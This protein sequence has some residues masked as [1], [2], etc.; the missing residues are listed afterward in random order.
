VSPLKRQPQNTPAGI[1]GRAKKEDFHN[2]T[3][4][5]GDCGG[6]SRELPVFRVK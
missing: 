6:N 3:S 5:M 4:A 1:A 2:R